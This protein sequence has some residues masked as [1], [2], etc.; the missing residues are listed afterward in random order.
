MIAKLAIRQLQTQWRKAE[1]RALLV[2]LLLMTSLMTLLNL[3]ADRLNQSLSVRSA[4]LLGAD[5][6][7]NSSRPIDPER[8]QAVQSYPVTT[9]EVTQFA[10]MVEAD[11]SMLLTSIRAITSPYPLRGEIITEPS[12][13]PTVPE[14]KTL[15]VE[16]AVL[17]R[18]NVKLGDSIHIGYEPFVISHRLLA[19]PDRGSGFRSFN[20]QIIMHQDDLAATGV[21][22]IGSRAEYRLL[23]SANASVIQQVSDNLEPQLNSWEKLTSVS[24]D[25]PAGRNV[26]SNASRY[27]KLSAVFALLMGAFAVFLSLRRYAADQHKRSALLL[28]FGLSQR[29]LILLYVIQLITAWLWVTPIGL[30]AGLGL[31]QLLLFWLADLLPQTLPSLSYFALFI[32]AGTGLAILLISGYSTLYPLTRTSILALMRSE[33]QTSA[34]ISRSGYIVA[35]ILLFLLLSLFVESWTLAV[36]LTSAL[37]IG[38]WLAGL[39]S[40]FLILSMSRLFKRLR[41]FAL[42]S[43][44]IRQQRFWHRLQGG[45]LTLLMTLMSILF[46][47]R[48]DLLTEWQGQLPADTP[49]HFVINIQPWEKDKV[50]SWLTNQGVNSTLYPMI[51]GRIASLNNQ[52]IETAFTPEQRQHNTLNRELN[53]TWASTRPAHNPIVAGEW[54]TA[55]DAISVE[56][57]MAEA[58]SLKLGDQLGFTVGSQTFSATITSIREVEWQSFQPNFYVIFSPGVIDKLPATYITSFKLTEGQR[59]IATELIKQFPT[60]TLIDVDQ[61]LTQAQ[62]LIQSLSDSASLIYLLTLFCGLT[63]VVMTLQ[64]SLMQRRYENA[65]LRTLGASERQTAQL[66][67]V[68]YLLLGFSCGLAASLLSEAIMFFVYSRLLQLEPNLH[69]SLWIVLPLLS[70]LLFASCGQMIRRPMNLAKSYSLLKAPG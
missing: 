70:T 60:L 41:L 25:Q 1:W 40:Q 26:L 5:L 66:D 22:G 51:R 54:S 53:L 62:S 58:L 38:G 3:T 2:A 9:S 34:L 28:S 36:I 61:L 50:D 18:L 65:L 21:L 10:S 52:S 6:I 11:S 37:L 46:F 67:R 8:K 56:K 35:S 59:L 4:E 33:T 45:V 12:E 13:H 24:K 55:D 49:N 63:L 27:L 20:P 47:I 14:P 16:Q 15:W 57:T 69:L 64:Q 31:H 39:A 29:K 19:S 43:L 30:L 7:L 23:I 32:S 44:R 48:Q 68:E 42:L 17:D